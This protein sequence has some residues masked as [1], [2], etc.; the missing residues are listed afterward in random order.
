MKIQLFQKRNNFKK[1]DFI[2][3]SNL[4]WKIIVSIAFVFILGSFVF[5]FRL[6]LQINQEFSMP[7]TNGNVQGRLINK[8]R[9]TKVLNYFSEKEKKTAEILN[10]S[11]PVVDP[12]L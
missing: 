10:S 1:K 5:G 11:I 7:E 6:F 8:D 4:Y 3:N 2:L 12:S 9:I